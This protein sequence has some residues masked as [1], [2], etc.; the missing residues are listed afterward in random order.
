LL[1]VMRMLFLYLP[2]SLVPSCPGRSMHIV[3][4]LQREQ[5]ADFYRLKSPALKL[6]KY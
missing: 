1:D 6:T 4:M 5:C 3:E 2:S